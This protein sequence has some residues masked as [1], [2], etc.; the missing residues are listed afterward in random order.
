MFSP[1]PGRLSILFIHVWSIPGDC[2]GV[3]PKQ[4][5]DRYI[6]IGNDFHASSRYGIGP[7]QDHMVQSTPYWDAKTPPGNVK[8]KKSHF[9]SELCFVLEAVT[10]FC[11]LIWRILYH[12]TSSCK[13]PIYIFCDLPFWSAQKHVIQPVF[14][15]FYAE[16]TLQF[17]LRSTKAPFTLQNKQASSDEYCI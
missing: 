3:T 11:V 16:K 13:G 15:M 9:F 2:Q 8:Q 14:R 10:F 1:I 12:V 7:L 6:I 17:R 4:T 5:S